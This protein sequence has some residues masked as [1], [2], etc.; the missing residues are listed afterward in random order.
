MPATRWASS[1]V[2]TRAISIGSAAPDRR[3]AD[4]FAAPIS[5]SYSVN[6]IYG[7]MQVPWTASFSTD[8]ALRYS[9]ITRPSARHRQQ[10]LGLRWQPVQ[11]LV[12][13]ATY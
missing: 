2:A 11:D 9:W 1:T 7:E 13:R 12:L 3:V 10:K 4:S 8:F 6:E 5:A